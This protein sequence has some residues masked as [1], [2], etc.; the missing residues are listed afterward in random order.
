MRLNQLKEKELFKSMVKKNKKSNGNGKVA[1]RNKSLLGQ[2]AFFTPE[3]LDDIN[4]KA[5]YG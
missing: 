1:D 5:E 2:N 3:V 4:I